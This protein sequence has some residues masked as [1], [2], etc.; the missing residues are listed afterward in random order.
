VCNALGALPGALFDALTLVEQLDLSLNG[1]RGLP[2]SIDKLT[3]LT[4][5]DLRSNRIGAEGA[6]ALKGLTALTSL[7]LG[8]NGIGAEG[9]QALKGLTA[10]SLD[11]GGND[12]I[13]LSP[14]KTLPRLES[15][16]LH[17]CTVAEA[18]PDL[19]DAVA[20]K[21]VRAQGCVLPGDIPAALL[22]QSHDD[23]CLPRLRAYYHS[24]AGAGAV[25]S[26]DVKV[27]LLGNGRV[28]KTKLR[29]RLEDNVW[30]PSTESTHGVHIGAA[31]LPA[32]AG[33][34]PPQ[35]PLKIWDFGGQDIYLG[36]HALFLRSRAIFPVLWAPESEPT[37]NPTHIWNETEHE[38]FPLG[39]W[40]RYVENMAGTASPLLLVQSQCENEAQRTWKSP[41]DEALWQPFQFKRP[42]IPYSARTDYGRELLTEGLQSA[43]AELDRQR[44]GDRLPASWAKVKAHIEVLRASDQKLPV[45]ERKFRTTSLADF[46]DVCGRIGRLKDEGSV[47]ALLRVLHDY[48][49][50]FWREGWFKDLIII[51]Q[52]WAL[53]AVYSVLD[54][55]SGV[56]RYLRDERRGRFTQLELDALLWGKAGHTGDEQ[57]VFIEMMLACGIC[58]VLRPERG[59]GDERIPAVYLAPDLLPA[60]RDRPG[61]L[62]DR[63][64]PA[65]ATERALFR[66]AFL[67]PGLLRGL[68][69]GLGEA[70]GDTGEYWREGF[71][72]FDGETGARLLV[73]ETRN[74]DWSGTVG[75]STQKGEARELLA[76]ISAMVL[77]QVRRL[78]VSEVEPTLPDGLTRAELEERRQRSYSGYR[79]RDARDANEGRHAPAPSEAPKRPAADSPTEKAAKA[80][81]AA[82]IEPGTGDECY[83]SYKHGDATAEG[84]KRQ[85]TFEALLA[86]L[87]ALDLTPVWDASEL[88]NNDSIEDFEKRIARGDKVA[89]VLSDGYLQSRFCVAEI[90]ALHAHCLESREEWRRRVRVVRV[91]GTPLAPEDWG[92]CA[93]YWQRQADKLEGQIDALKKSTEALALR[94]ERENYIDFA[95]KLPAIL[96]T[97]SDTLHIHDLARLNELEFASAQPVSAATRVG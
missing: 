64:E 80:P 35:T 31:T 84:Q 76:R 21:N 78:G 16:T 59:E 33:G 20:L 97:I 26:R 5:L 90:V 93:L 42:Y 50:V 4:S 58:F 11:L 40:V 41:V 87:R 36:T 92:A 1:L 51:D 77:D 6:Q 49:T 94:Q 38:N 19:W 29:R 61:V 3:A 88:R 48:G 63:W 25:T 66:F 43:V 91:A 79:L 2:A 56:F 67:P 96:K 8:G 17:S 34:T 55:D 71:F 46:A 75:L 12:G 27:M 65:L 37:A 72:L 83:I 7:D 22:S 45:A 10:L 57:R 82:A 39:Y 15:L 86:R 60:R 23:N 68:M 70:A 53:G 44:P 9:A 14:L 73:E 62:A 85:E 13:D 69:A 74:T 52:Q 47:D 54:R 95:R 30:D 28:G 24:L 32:A 81:I 89:I 18:P